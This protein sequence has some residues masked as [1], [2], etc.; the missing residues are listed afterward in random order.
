MAMLNYQ[1]VPME[2]GPFT[3]GS[4]W[5]AYWKLWLSIAKAW[6]LEIYW[7]INGKQNGFNEIVME[8]HEDLMRYLD[9]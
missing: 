1:R 6:K 5:F 9:P 4:W 7:D 3:R 2:N 8:K